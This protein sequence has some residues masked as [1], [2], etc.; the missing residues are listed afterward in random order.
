M[1]GTKIP[2]SQILKNWW[3]KQC[4]RTVLHGQ[5]CVYYPVHNNYIAESVLNSHL[6]P[7]AKQLAGLGRSVQ[8]PT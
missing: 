7:N 3:S 8:V 4:Y 5:T 6:I 2:Q 1:H